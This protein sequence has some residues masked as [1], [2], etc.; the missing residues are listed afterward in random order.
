MKKTILFSLVIVLLV[1]VSRWQIPVTWG[2]PLPQ[3]MFFGQ[4]YSSNTSHFTFT[5]GHNFAVASATKTGFNATGD[6]FCVI[7]SAGYPPSGKTF[8]STPSNTWNVL[9]NYVQSNGTVWVAYTTF[10]ASVS[11]SMTFNSGT[12]FASMTGACFNDSGSLGT[13]DSGSTN[14]N[15][16]AGASSTIQPGTA[17]IAGSNELV[18][19][20][21][22]LDYNSVGFWNSVD[23]GF[24]LIGTE[25]GTAVPVIG[26]SSAFLIQTTASNV[27]PTWTLLSGSLPNT[28]SSIAA[29]KP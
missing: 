3:S 12:T 26:N 9:T 27:N 16:Q 7:A 24:T 25:A 28:N 2:S 6:N 11:S 15:T 1:T 21:A 17:T 4:N 5:S 29:F 13:L 18:I 10:P 23:S 19:T 20:V 8:S 22:G 14:G